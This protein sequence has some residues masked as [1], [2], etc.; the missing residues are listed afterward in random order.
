MIKNILSYIWVGIE[1]LI[2]V[3]VGMM[4]WAL[5]AIIVG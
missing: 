1:F 2:V 3:G 5:M 4:M